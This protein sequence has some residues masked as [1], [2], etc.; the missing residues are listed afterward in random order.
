MYESYPHSDMENHDCNFEM[1][2]LALLFIFSPFCFL[3]LIN[4][5]GRM[6]MNKQNIQNTRRGR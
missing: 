1:K 4:K 5:T 2:I 3:T 6:L